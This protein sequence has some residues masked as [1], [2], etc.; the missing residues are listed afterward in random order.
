[1]TEPIWLE[2]ARKELGQSEVAGLK[3]NPRIIEYLKSVAIPPSI[4]LHDEIYWCAAFINWC[5][6]QSN[7]QG[8]HSPAARAFLN[9]GDHLE[10]PKIGCITVLKRGTSWQGHVGLWLGET[11]DCVTLIS[12][13]QSNKV[14]IANFLK[15]DVL[16][17]RY[18]RIKK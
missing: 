6:L 4:K 14:S 3:D 18:P 17:Y 10:K 15:A 9:F 8:T 12:G 7:I 16:G 1:M 5:L 2:I 11:Q 13:N